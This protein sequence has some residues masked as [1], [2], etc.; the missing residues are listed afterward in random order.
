MLKERRLPQPIASCNVEGWDIAARTK[1]I[2]FASASGS[3]C[4]EG[5]ARGARWH[6]RARRKRWDCN[7]L[8]CKPAPKAASRRLSRPWCNSVRVPSWLSPTRSF[9]TGANSSFHWR[10]AMRFPRSIPTVV[11]QRSAEPP[12]S[13]GYHTIFPVFTRLIPV[14]GDVDSLAPPSAPEQLAV[15]HWTSVRFC[16]G[17]PRRVYAA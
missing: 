1:G 5:R 6:V 4:A 14:C 15:S 11:I 13:I 8:C 10:R 12:A 2:E 16:N 9:W 3:R 17:C 7:W